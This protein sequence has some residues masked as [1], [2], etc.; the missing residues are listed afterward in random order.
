[1]EH[2]L[3]LTLVHLYLSILGATL[4]IIIGLPLGILLVRYR[5]L[6]EIMMAVT[7]IIQTIPG[8]AL[9]ALVMMVTGLG[10]T[11]LVITLFLYSLMPVVRNTYVGISGIDPGLVEAGLGMGMTRVQLLRQVQLPIAMPVILAGIRVAMITSIG[12]A[13]MGVFIGADGLGDLLYRGI[14]T[15]NLRLLLSGAIP[16]ALLAVITDFIMM[17]LEHLLTPKGL[18]IS[19]DQ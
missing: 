4:G 10:N 6:A 1:M 5:R 19:A 3:L 18:R 13:T 9:L 11:T 8:L 14:Q 7:E 17:Y 15:T 2:I 12:I 16:A